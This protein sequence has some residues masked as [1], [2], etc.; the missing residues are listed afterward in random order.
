MVYP[1]ALKTAVN[2][3][4]ARMIEQVVSTDGAFKSAARFGE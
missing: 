1:R 3:R 2:D 4:T